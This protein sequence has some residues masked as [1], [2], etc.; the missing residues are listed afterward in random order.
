MP[1]EQFEKGQYVPERQPSVQQLA[2]FLA[3]V[4]HGS[5]AAA[6]QSLYIAQPS[7]SDQIRRLEAGLGVRLFTRTKRRA[8]LTDS[9]QFATQWAHRAPAN[10]H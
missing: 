2:Y 10:V 7:R 9:V 4:Q 3:S 5:L 1:M 6:A 8:I